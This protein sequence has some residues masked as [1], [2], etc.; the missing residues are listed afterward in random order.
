MSCERWELRLAN[1][2]TGVEIEQ[3]LAECA[4]C[5]W[6]A[7]ELRENASA[8]A[9]MRDEVMPERRG[10]RRWP[11]VAA[12]LAA[13]AMVAMMVW[14]RGE[15]PAASAAPPVRV[16][17]LPSVPLP[18]PAPEKP[19]PVQRAKPK[20]KPKPTEPLLVKMLTDDPEVVIYWVIEGEQAI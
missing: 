19:T 10:S 5:R 16:N 13:A 15:D 2:E 3:H 20:P 8:L 18:V 12:A 4:E 11:F 6:L 17:A 14:P 7:G 1:G 9:A